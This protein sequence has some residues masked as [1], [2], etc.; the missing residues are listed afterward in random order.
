[1]QINFAH[2]RER[3]TNGGDI[4]FAVF[5]ARAN[6]NSDTAR[7]EVLADLTVRA[8]QSGLRVD[9][10]ALAFTE[11]GRIKFYGTKNLVDY[12]SR[13]WIPHWT[14]KLSV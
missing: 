12:L 10:S 2:L 3:A 7:S 14:H 5:E 6:S 1:M 4:N 8:R 9:Q 13:G 11:N